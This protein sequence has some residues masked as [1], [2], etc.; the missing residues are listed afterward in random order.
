M[1]I[2]FKQT[3]KV[4]VCSTECLENETLVLYKYLNY[5]FR[6]LFALINMKRTDLTVQMI[7]YNRRLPLPSYHNALWHIFEV[8]VLYIFRVGCRTFFFHF[9]RMGQEHYW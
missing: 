7:M 8:E 5:A 6:D 3:F 2:R 1:F 4:K 9:C